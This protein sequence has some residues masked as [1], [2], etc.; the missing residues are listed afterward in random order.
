M[1]GGG[2]LSNLLNAAGDILRGSLIDVDRNGSLT[3]G[4]TGGG[5]P[6]LEFTGGGTGGGG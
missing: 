4:G 2:A 3:G 6:A 1:A 5:G